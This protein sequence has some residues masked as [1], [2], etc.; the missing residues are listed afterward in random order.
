VISPVIGA[1]AES[2]TLSLSAKASAMKAAG[3]DVIAFAAG[4]PDFDTPEFI[5]DAAI[6]A[7]KAG[8][9]KYAPVA[10]TPEL[11]QAIAE[12]LKKENGLDYEPSEIGVGR[13]RGAHPGALLGDVSRAGAGGARRPGLRGNA[14]PGRL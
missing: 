13:R 4:E 10:G 11:R 8:K 2:A 3:E 1:I 5:K 6:K 9:T 12:K 14:C 7:L